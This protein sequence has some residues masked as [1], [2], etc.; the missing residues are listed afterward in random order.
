M[1]LLLYVPV[2]FYLGA[3]DSIACFKQAF[4]L[5]KTFHGLNCF[6]GFTPETLNSPQTTS[7]CGLAS[8]SM[9]FFGAD[10]LTCAQLFVTA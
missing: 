6:S 4:G 8:E 1:L 7:G 2:V 5:S 10:P 9:A 3:F